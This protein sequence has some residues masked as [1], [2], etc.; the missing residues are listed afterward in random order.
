MLLLGIISF[1]IIAIVL[2]LSLWTTSKA[3]EYQHKIDTPPD[4]KKNHRP[5]PK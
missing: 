2:I 3:Y 5:N 4:S 1:I